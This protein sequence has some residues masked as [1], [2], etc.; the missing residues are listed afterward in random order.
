MPGQGKGCLEL[1]TMGLV[2]LPLLP[3]THPKFPA[4]PSQDIFECQSSPVSVSK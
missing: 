2:R 4:A 1:G 3:D